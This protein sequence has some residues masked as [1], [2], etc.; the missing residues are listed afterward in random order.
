MAVSHSSQLINIQIIS[1]D[2]LRRFS[3]ETDLPYQRFCCP[4]CCVVHLKNF[5]WTF[6]PQC[7]VEN[8]ANDY[9]NLLFTFESTIICFDV[10]LIN[11]CTFFFSP[12]LSASLVKFQP[13][14]WV[15]LGLVPGTDEMLKE[16]PEKGAEIERIVLAKLA[17]DQ[18]GVTEADLRVV[19]LCPWV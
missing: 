2:N 12:S 3:D 14:R 6:F 7:I 4:D 19:T 10:Y 11:I 15:V 8:L 16:R 5:V 9:V 17:W 18:T 13:C 1:A